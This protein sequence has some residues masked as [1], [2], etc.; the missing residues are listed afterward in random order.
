MTQS[1]L[2]KLK[3][4][5]YS[6]E[7]LYNCDQSETNDLLILHFLDHHANPTPTLDKIRK[8]DYDCDQSETDTIILDK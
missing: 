2:I 4:D 5:F 3:K 1:S 8:Q 6:E 7:K